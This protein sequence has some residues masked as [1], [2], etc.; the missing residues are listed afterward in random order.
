[1]S[2]GY[3]PQFKCWKL[4]AQ[5]CILHIFKAVQ[6]NDKSFWLD[7]S[8]NTVQRKLGYLVC[9]ARCNLIL[10]KMRIYCMVVCAYCGLQ[11]YQLCMFMKPS[12]PAKT[13]G[14]Y[15]A[16]NL[17]LHL[18]FIC[19]DHAPGCKQVFLDHQLDLFL[20]SEHLGAFKKK[21]PKRPPNNVS[22]TAFPKEHYLNFYVGSK[23]TG[24]GLVCSRSFF[25][26][27]CHCLLTSEFL[28]VA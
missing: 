24:I 4:D 16:S 20:K 12:R 6:N 21:S 27:F 9:S 1:M 11:L 17:L 23:N 7:V 28:C 10:C 26:R 15:A 3:V 13:E 14:G 19:R 2:C 18:G 22:T 5:D 8:I 25:S